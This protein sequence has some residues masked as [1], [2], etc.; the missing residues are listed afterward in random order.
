MDDKIKEILIITQEECAEIIQSISKIFRF[1][2][3]DKGFVG[4]SNR[5]RLE[6]EIGDLMCM[7]HLLSQEG[8]INDTNV[9]NS[10][11]EKLE[12]LKK[13]SSIFK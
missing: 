5:D 7:F 2:L 11:I 8:I 6:S 3:D 13:W 9:E 1:G 4:T 10:L 12:R